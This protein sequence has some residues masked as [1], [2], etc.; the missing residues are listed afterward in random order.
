[1]ISAIREVLGVAA[2]YEKDISARRS[3]ILEAT[4]LSLRLLEVQKEI[5]DK[6]FE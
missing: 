3:Y 6:Y 4:R 5:E 2:Y 1:M